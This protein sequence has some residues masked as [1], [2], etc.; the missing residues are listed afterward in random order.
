MEQLMWFSLGCYTW[1][2]LAFSFSLIQAFPCVWGSMRRGYLVAFVTMIP[3][4]TDKSS[5][6][7][8]WRFHSLILNIQT[9]LWMHFTTLIKSY[10]AIVEACV[11]MWQFCVVLTVGGSTRAEIRLRFSVKGI[12]WLL[13]SASQMSFNNIS[14]KLWL[15]GPQ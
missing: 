7:S 3:F 5:P 11:F 9:Q 2:E 13:S 14:R 4:C 6:G 8:P 15:N 10:A 12:L 1:S